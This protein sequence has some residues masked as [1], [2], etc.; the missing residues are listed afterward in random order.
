[1][2]RYLKMSTVFAVAFFTGIPWTAKGQDSTIKSNQDQILYTVQKAAANVEAA[3][4]RVERERA[5]LEEKEAELKYKSIMISTNG[6]SMTI[7]ATLRTKPKLG[8]YLSNLDFKD[9]YEQHYP[10]NY[11]VMVSG[12]VKGGASDLAGM[13]EGDIIMTF[14][15]TKVLYDDQLVRLINSKQIGDAVPITVFRNESIVDLTVTLA[16]S[17]KN[18]A[19]IEGTFSFD[20]ENY[21]KNVGYG[22]GGWTP[23]W[24]QTDLTD[25]NNLLSALNFETIGTDG[26]LLQGGGGHGNVG[27]GWF[28]GGQGMGYMINRKVGMTIG[29][30][31]DSAY[32][33]RQIQLNMGMG[34]V[35]LDKRFVLSKKILPS[36]G[37]MIGGG[38][39]Q[40][41]VSQTN[42]AY[43]WGTDGQGF[44]Q[45]LESSTN[46]SI[47][48]RRDYIVVQP[49]LGL[50][51]RVLPWM[52]IRAEGGYAYGYSWYK[53]WK[54]TV[55]EDT[56]V[57]KNSPETPLQ[58]A[59]ASVGLWFGY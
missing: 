30:G 2:K 28:L 50:L 3:A 40:L 16:A 49:R 32:V 46:N 42:G 44:A 31:A 55:G 8:V 1:M 21:G 51:I 23:T 37:V 38:S 58:G 36:L 6:D 10:Y 41:T 57:L 27:N 19:E 17:K 33:T 9:A 22:G 39:Y 12:V 11:G 7:D 25:V 4:A 48:L 5:K 14:D 56:Y 29:A 54:T 47:E 26:I 52:S 13:V 59:T 18:A 15:S 43:N 20:M 45:D 53:G 24:L 35:T 34:G